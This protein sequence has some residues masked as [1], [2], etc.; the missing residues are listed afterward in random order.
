MST[1]SPVRMT[2][3]HGAVSTTTGLIRPSEAST[4]F[5]PV[6]DFLQPIA[7]AYWSWF[8]YAFARNENS[9]PVIFSTSTAVVG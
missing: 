3:L 4:I 1:S 2:S 7:H 6:S 5:I 9:Q 8:E